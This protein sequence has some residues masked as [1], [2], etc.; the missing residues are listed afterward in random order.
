MNNTKRRISARGKATYELRGMR[1]KGHGLLQRMVR[2]RPGHPSRSRIDCSPVR[3]Q[4]RGLSLR[5][6]ELVASHLEPRAGIIFVR[7]SGVEPRGGVAWFYEGV[8]D[9]SMGGVLLPVRV[10]DGGG[11]PGVLAVRGWSGGAGH[12][13]AG[14]QPAV[15]LGRLA[16]ARWSGVEMGETMSQERYSFLTIACAEGKET[17]LDSWALLTDEERQ[18][19]TD[20]MLL[21][22]ELGLEGWRA[23]CDR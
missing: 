4:G 23:Y 22:R 9:C 19:H 1:R 15:G 8:F 3:A 16:L 14:V 5:A 7:P 2:K 18:A 20:K 6:L 17:W 10:C 12:L 11:V 13:V 21:A